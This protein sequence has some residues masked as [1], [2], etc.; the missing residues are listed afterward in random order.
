MQEIKETKEVICKRC[1][2]C[3][4]VSEPW[5]LGDPLDISV[6]IVGQNPGFPDDG[7]PNP[8]RAFFGHSYTCGVYM[9][10]VSEFRGV[11]LTNVV[12]CA[13]VKEVERGHIRKCAAIFLE[14]EIAF[15]EPKLILCVGNVAHQA[16]T[17]IVPESWDDRVVMVTHPGYM[18]RMGWDEAKIGLYSDNVFT[19]IQNAITCKYDKVE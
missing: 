9:N 3:G 13:H 4:V 16:V 5:I 2:R 8:H 18:K 6:M 17:Q 11:Y 19:L 10:I 14:Y 7:H 12:K 1:P 15:F